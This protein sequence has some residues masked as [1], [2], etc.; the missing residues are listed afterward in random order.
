MFAT[1]FSVFFN[2][3]TCRITLNINMTGI[4]TLNLFH[5]LHPAV[6]QEVQATRAHLEYQSAIYFIQTDQ[7][8]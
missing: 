8:P 6:E 7:L 3:V 1:F 5:F 2:I 4:V